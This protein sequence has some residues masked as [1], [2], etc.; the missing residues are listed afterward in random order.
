M[1][2]HAMPC[3]AMPC[4]A[5]L[6][7]ATLCYAM[8]CYAMLCR[9]CANDQVLSQQEQLS[10]RSIYLWQSQTVLH[11]DLVFRLVPCSC[12]RGLYLCWNHLGRVLQ[13][14][15]YLRW[16][17]ISVISF[18]LFLLFVGRVKK[19]CSRAA[20]VSGSMI[21]ACM[22]GFGSTRQRCI[23]LAVLKQ[24]AKQADVMVQ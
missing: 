13:Q 19:Y 3:H 21:W 17:N 16:S 11:S 1:P 10:D 4:H 8:L 6:C 20:F 2:C 18:C 23:C 22:L 9:A 5:M 7:Y 15:L 14:N 24:W 12:L